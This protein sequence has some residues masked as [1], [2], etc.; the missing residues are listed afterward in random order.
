MRSLAI[1]IEMFGDEIEK[2]LDLCTRLT[3][4]IIRDEEEIFRLPSNTLRGR[5]RDH[6][7]R[8]R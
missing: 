5:P 8:Y 2:T 3:G 6:E 1:R 4:E 7:A